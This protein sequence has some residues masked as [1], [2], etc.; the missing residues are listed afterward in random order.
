MAFRE[1]KRQHSVI[2]TQALRGGHDRATFSNQL[3]PA[4][5]ESVR[6]HR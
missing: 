3:L 2:P 1:R 4:C 5:V 6:A